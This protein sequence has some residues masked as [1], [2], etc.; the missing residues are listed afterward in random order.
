MFRAAI[1][2]QQTLDICLTQGFYSFTN[3]KKQAGEE[4]VYSAYT[5]H[6]AVD[7]QRKLGLELKQSRKQEPKQ[8]LWRDVTYWFASP[9][10]LSLL[11]NTTQD[12]H[13][14]DVTNHRGYSPWS[15]IEKM[16]NSWI[17]WRPTE[18]PFSVITP[19]CVSWHT[20]PAS[21]IS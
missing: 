8:R 11:Y 12:Y 20:K 17:S 16:F 1:L 18:D 13:P 15:L 14:R 7:H 4:R 9:G 6:I 5:F 19:A 21:T 2:W 10:L 3:I